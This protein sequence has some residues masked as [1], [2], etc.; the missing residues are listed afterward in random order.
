[1]MCMTLYAIRG[2]LTYDI[3]IAIARLKVVVVIEVAATFAVVR[4]VVTVMAT[5][6]AEVAA[7]TAVST[8]IIFLIQ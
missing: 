4:T 8:R 6:M 2:R 3:V 7:A 5:A 1:M